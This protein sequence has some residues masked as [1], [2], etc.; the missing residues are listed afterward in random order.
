[1]GMKPTGMTLEQYNDLGITTPEPVAWYRPCQSV[2][3]SPYDVPDHGVGGVRG[4]PGVSP[5]AKSAE[6]LGGARCDHD[7]TSSSARAAVS[8]SA[9]EAAG[10]APAPPLATLAVRPASAES[11]THQDVPGERQQLL[12]FYQ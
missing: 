8:S 2:S 7:S 9:P 3:V 12:R 6:Q 4:H 10:S 1:M 5:G 11:S